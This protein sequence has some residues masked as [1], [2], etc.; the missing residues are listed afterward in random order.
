MTTFVM[1]LSSGAIGVV[2]GAVASWAVCRRWRRRHLVGRLSSDAAAYT[3]LDR[4]AAEWAERAGRPELA[5]LVASKLRLVHALSRRRVG[6][7]RWRWS[8]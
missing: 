1:T 8:R 6:R 7:N 5:G 3:E 4:A 2:M